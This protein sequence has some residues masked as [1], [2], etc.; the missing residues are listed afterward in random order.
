MT[1]ATVAPHLEWSVLARF[2]EYVR[3]MRDGQVH[4]ED[5]AE[6]LRSGV[7][8]F[9]LLDTRVDADGCT[10]ATFCGRV[11]F[12]GHGGMLNLPLGGIQVRLGS[13]GSCQ[14]SISDPDEP[15]VRL[16]FATA[17]ADSDGDALKLSAALAED[18]SELFFYRYPRGFA[19]DSARVVLDSPLLDTIASL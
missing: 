9:P 19:L 8:R 10:V 17:S 13:G 5:G 1:A 7:F 11:R 6:E 2:T 14:V 12:S 4:L 15:L 18:G 16:L 3:G